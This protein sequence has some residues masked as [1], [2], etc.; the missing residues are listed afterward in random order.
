MLATKIHNALV[1]LHRSTLACGH[2]WI[3]HPHELDTLKRQFLQFIEIRLPA[4]SFCEIIIENLSSNKAAD[5][6]IG[7]VAGIWYEH[8]ITRIKECK[9][10]VQDSFF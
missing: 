3:I 6:C 7:R 5:R 1:Q 2:V 8:A 4:I 9:R 10:N